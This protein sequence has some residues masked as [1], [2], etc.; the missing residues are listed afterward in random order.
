MV[1]LQI[2]PKICCHSN[3][4]EELE[5]EVGPDKSSTNTYHLL[6]AKIAKI[7]LVDPE[8]ICIRVIIKK[9]TRSI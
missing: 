8:I 4:L 6:P 7:S 3:V 9:I 2:L 5:K 1:I